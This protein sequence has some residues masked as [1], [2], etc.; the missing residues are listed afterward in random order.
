MTE[1]RPKLLLRGVFRVEDAQG[2]RIAI[3]SAKAQG[4]LALVAMSKTAERTRAWLQAKLWSDRGPEQASQSLRTELSALRRQLDRVGIDLY[5]DRKHIRLDLERVD[6]VLDGSGEFLE[7]IDVRDE[8][9]EEWLT[10]ERAQ[11]SNHLEPRSEASCPVVL[12]R[13]RP[14]PVEDQ[15]RIVLS[16]RSRDDLVASDF[17]SLLA[18][19]LVRSLSETFTAPVTVEADPVV[20]DALLICEVRCATTQIGH[21]IL[22]LRVQH[23]AAGHEVWSAQC[24]MKAEFPSLLDDPALMQIV[25]D[26]IEAVE[27]YVAFSHLAGSAASGPDALFGRAMRSLFSMNPDQVLAADQ[28]L[29]RAIDQMPRGVFFAWRAQL[30]AIQLIERHPVDEEA[31]TEEGTQLYHRALELDPTNSMVLATVANSVRRLTRDHGYSH[32]LAE[33]SLA[34]NRWNP[35]AHWALSAAHVYV[36]NNTEAYQNAQIGQSL[37]LLSPY[38]FWWETQVYS[39]A[40]VSGRNDEALMHVR[41]AHYGNTKFKPPLRYLIALYALSGDLE[42]AREAVAKLQ[43]LEPGFDPMEL[44]SRDYPT[45]VLWRSPNIDLDRLSQICREL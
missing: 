2:E 35:L 5:A 28:L 12:R 17:E 36:G 4:L 14:Q 39:S 42:N 9:F 3:T 40:L 30:R 10:Q 34:R 37:K 6:I 15:L 32:Y 21:Q 7:G 44:T 1:P 25:N 13:E 19:A 33:R 18:S 23:P 43:A 27:N 31:T 29:L 38:R 41:N 8:A 24:Q 22:F 26:L 16:P 45:S 11:Y 20:T